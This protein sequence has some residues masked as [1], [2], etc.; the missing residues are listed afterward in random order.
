MKDTDTL[1]QQ[2]FDLGEL[3]LACLRAGDMNQAGSMARERKALVE[4]LCAL[5]AHA[6][7]AR[8]LRQLQKQQ[9]RLTHEAR[10]LQE[11]LKQ[12][13]LRVRGQSKRYGGYRNAATVTSPSS[14]FLN[15]RG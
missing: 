1:V 5:K 4:R 12:E 15:K 3:E 7:L 2:A 8:K 6:G 9:T 13:L 10:E 14:R 11:R